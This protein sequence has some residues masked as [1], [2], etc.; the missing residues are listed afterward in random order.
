[1]LPF[2]I[3]LA[4][5]LLLPLHAFF[6]TWL[7][8]HF[9]TDSWM[10]VVQA[11]KEIL[12]AVLVTATGWQWVR[13]PRVPGGRAGWLAIAFLG[14]AAGFFVFGAGSWGAKLFGLRSLALFFV[15]FLSI[16]F[17][18]FSSRQ[19]TIL[20]RGLL[21]VA[22]A[23]GLF[24]LLQKFVLPVDFLRH[25]GYSTVVSTWLPG[26]NLP[27]YHLV[28]GT[29]IVRLQATFAGPNQLAAWWLAVLPLAF[30]AL[31]N[32]RGGW[33]MVAAV[34]AG[35]GAFTLFFTYS[36]AAWLG[37][38]LAVGVAALTFWPQLSRR[39]RVAAAT[40]GL[41]LLLGG[42]ALLATQPALQTAVLRHASSSEHLQKSLAAAKLL[43]HSP[44]GL[45]LGSTAGAGARTAGEA[46][47]LTPENTFLTA[48]L[49]L[50]W[51][52]GL[53]FLAAY[54]AVAARLHAAG[55]PVFYSLLAI[56]VVL[57]FLHPLE[58]SP[59]ALTLGLLAGL[60]PFARK[61]LQN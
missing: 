57:F 43:W 40:G 10:V 51:L 8:A 18:T 15:S 56:G 7:H 29:Q 45:G 31:K 55:S 13:Q 26:G 24:A 27:M 9:W 52:G 32:W 61:Q 5:L 14:L 30:V 46:K 25:F 36:R 16:Q 50:G 4:L 49:E 2:V 47:S 33:R 38:L 20:L 21:A 17:F 59:T 3:T 12:L 22:A 48:G 54:T 44:A 28:G 39:V 60:T 1:M 58:D 6:Y 35:A 37:A 19:T 34:A 41:L 23:V 11:W 53:L 42:G